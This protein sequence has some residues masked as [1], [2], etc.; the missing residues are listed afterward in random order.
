MAKTA[1]PKPDTKINTL[2]ID[3]PMELALRRKSLGLSC[4][5]N[6]IRLVE[7][8][9]GRF[10]VM[11]RM[12]DRLKVDLAG[13]ATGTL[14]HVRFQ[15]TRI[16]RKLSLTELAGAFGLT[17]GRLTDL[18]RGSGKVADFLQVLP[19][20]APKARVRGK[21]SAPG[22]KDKRYTPKTVLWSSCAAFA[23]IDWDPCGHRDSHLSE[24]DGNYL[25][26][27]DDGLTQAWGGTVVFM[28][29]PFSGLSKWTDKFLKEAIANPR[30]IHIALIPAVT[31]S[32]FFKLAPEHGGK[33]FLFGERTRFEKPGGTSEPSNLGMAL[34]VFGADDHQ[35]RSFE[36]LEKGYWW[37][38][39]FALPQTPA[40]C[41]RERA[42]NTSHMRREEISLTSCPNSSASAH[43][44]EKAS[45][46]RDDAS[47]PIMKELE[48]E[49]RD[50][51]GLR[52]RAELYSRR[53]QTDPD[54]LLS[55]AIERALRCPR[56]EK[57]VGERIESILSSIASTMNRSRAR[58][59]LRGVYL[60]SLDDGT[61]VDRHFPDTRNPSQAVEME[62]RRRGSQKALELIA[63]GDLKLHALIDGIGLGFR[64]KQ[65]QVHMG[66][67]K[68]QLATLRRRLKRSAEAARA[69]L[70]LERRLAVHW[71][72]EP[73]G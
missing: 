31:E 12:M 72:D 16:K 51:F 34:V 59:R 64:G 10:E 9:K 68:R 38:R 30:K 65:L 26:R 56:W 71:L 28:N 8:G 5:A 32:R 50:P 42:H 66:M 19:V 53:C 63:N 43:V 40:S 20:L 73:A 70:G 48:A 41:S 54:D 23:Q 36:A 7:R 4:E 2:T 55:I 18:E 11:S 69:S 33:I 44:E 22:E 21:G 35:R 61:I 3:L 1:T 47:C 57:G 15:D 58:G 62:A 25:D 60:V 14:L 29:P 17:E 49:F 6:D 46:R 67:T 13:I 24:V 52:K 45:A 27:G 39:E 37:V